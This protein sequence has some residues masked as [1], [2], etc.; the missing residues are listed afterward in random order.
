MLN[1]RNVSD[2]DRPKEGNCIRL[3]DPIAALKGQ[4]EDP[5]DEIAAPRMALD[6]A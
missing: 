3:A 1:A 4:G 6:Q 2:D 5:L